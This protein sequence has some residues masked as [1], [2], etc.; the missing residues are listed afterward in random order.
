MRQFSSHRFSMMM[1]CLGLS[2]GLIVALFWMLGGARLPTVQAG[3]PIG[4][5]EMTLAACEARLS[6]GTNDGLIYPSIQ[7]A[8]N[9]ATPLSDLIKVA[10]DCVGAELQGGE[11]QIAYISKSLTIRGGYTSTNWTASD[12]AVNT[13]TLDAQWSGRGLIHY[14]REIG[15]DGWHWSC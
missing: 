12:P 14:E 15:F 9:A 3:P 2:T 1:M 4:G 11:Y 8:V 13:T 6:D 5:L 10:G 7:S